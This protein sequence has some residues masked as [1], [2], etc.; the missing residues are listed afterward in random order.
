ML[1]FQVKFDELQKCCINTMSHK[2][3]YIYHL[4]FSLFYWISIFIW[5]M[6]LIRWNF[7]P[8]LR[9]WLL[10][11]ALVLKIFLFFCGFLSNFPALY[12]PFT[13]L[14][15]ICF[16]CSRYVFVSNHVSVAVGY[17]STRMSIFL[18]QRERGKTNLSDNGIDMLRWIKIDP[19][20]R[21]TCLFVKTNLTHLTCWSRN[22]L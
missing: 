14:T 6:M 20:A 9:F 16:T 8:V 7:K 17:I 2:K 19:T 15:S 4:T 11:T 3:S 5:S 21:E 12:P 22:E 10:S 18:T 13:S 1:T